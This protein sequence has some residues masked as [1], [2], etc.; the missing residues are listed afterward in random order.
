VPTQAGDAALPGANARAIARWDFVPYH[1]I[2]A[3]ANVGVVAFHIN[4][5][6]RVSF[7]ANGGPWVDVYEMKRN[8]QTG[9]WEYF[10]TVNP[11]DFPD[12]LV[13]VRAVA[14]PTSGV[15]RGLQG[16]REGN[17][18]NGD[19]SMFL[20]TNA[21]GT[22]KSTERWVSTT[23]SDTNDGLTAAT[24]MRTIAKAAASIHVAQQGNAGGGFINMLPG[25][26]SWSGSGVDQFG[27][28]VPNPVTTDRWLTVRR[29]PGSQGDVTF[30]SGMTA[31]ALATKLLAVES[32]R[33]IGS[34]P[35]RAG[36]TPNGLIWIGNCE[37]R[38][39]N[40]SD[41]VQFIDAG[42]VGGYMTQTSI[43]QC[44]TGVNR[45]FLIRDVHISQ[46]GKDA[47]T[48]VPM[49]LNSTASNILRP[50]GQTWHCD[51]LQY[52]KSAVPRSNVIIY[53]FKAFD[54]RSQGL[55]ARDGE[56]TTPVVWRDFAFVNFF[57]EFAQGS[58]HTA[59]WR[60][61]TDHMLIWN[62]SFI[63]G[64]FMLRGFEND[65]MPLNY[66]NLSIQGCVFTKISIGETIIP[67]IR[68]SNNHFI[69]SPVFGSAATLGN[70]LYISP[71]TN[72]YR[73]GPGSP[74]LERLESALVPV[75]SDLKLVTEP[76]NIGSFEE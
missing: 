1:T 19:H 34:S 65:G 11:A 70:P 74:L 31:G 38:G 58:T 46:I 54:N 64:T 27:A 75:D 42:F 5:I 40:T 15:P 16:P 36:S 52:S 47:V 24:A 60:I 68:A 57:D 14:Y 66:S 43:S 71:A 9:V 72:D 44:V 67:A 28:S 45:A 35:N 18:R 26:Y 48:T 12:G 59:Q 25:E 3:P 55:I 56:A 17:E 41:A 8:P 33:F 23:G 62:S 63:G 10:V 50:L 2:T 37:L 69:N 49:V 30:S 32:L 39:A 22:L 4:G 21:N 73:P 29:A 6:E 51:V 76:S 53:G 61:S 20:W 13:E 7:S